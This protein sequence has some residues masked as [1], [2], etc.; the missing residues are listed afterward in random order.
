MNFLG[1]HA[2]EDEASHEKVVL[3][4]G[5]SL[6]FYEARSKE[7][8]WSVGLVFTLKKRGVGN[9]TVPQGMS[10]SSDAEQGVTRPCRIGCRSHHV[11]IRILI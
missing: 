7:S 9:V 1:M 11:R 3:I 4:C 2:S 5:D 6:Y 8:Y 10:G